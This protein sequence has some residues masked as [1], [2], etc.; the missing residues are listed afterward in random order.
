MAK[1]R[2]LVIF[3]AVVCLLSG[4]VF[5]PITVT[6]AIPVIDTQNILQQ[7]KTFEQEAMTVIN[8]AKQ[9]ELQYKELLNLPNQIMSSYKSLLNSEIG[10]IQDLLK[11]TTGILNPDKK[12]DDLWISL[13]KPAGDLTKTT[14]TSAT[15]AAASSSLNKS[16][17]KANYESFE[18]V[19]GAMS[20]ITQTQK[21][22]DDLLELNKSSEGAKQT[23]QVQNM[24]LAEQAK[25]LQQQNLLRAAEANARITHYQRQNELDA[26]AHAIGQK[27]AEAVGKMD[28][29]RKAFR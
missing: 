10:Q 18:I 8:T 27:A 6:A 16:V 7:L 12:L 22:I 11:N 15:A 29:S 25:L 24:L 2:G 9:I 19:K 1:S 23:G 17:D 4:A 5:A 26:L 13:F 28:V 14:V 3:L 21:N 20:N